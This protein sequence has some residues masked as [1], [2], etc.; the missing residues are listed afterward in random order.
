MSSSKEENDITRRQFLKNAA[1]GAG[2]AFLPTLHGITAKASSHKKVISVVQDAPTNIVPG[3]LTDQPGVNVCTAIYDKLFHLQGP[4]SE[5]G[6]WLV[7]DYNVSSDAKRW[8]FKLKE[9]V[10]FH[11]GTELTAEDVVFTFDRILNPDLGSAAQS[12]FTVVDNVEKKDQYT[13]NFELKQPNPNF[14][15]KFY[16]YNTQILAKDYD[17]DEYGSTK[18]SGTGPFKMKSYEP[19]SRVVL[20]RNPDY[21]V[22]DS[23]RVDELHI[24]IVPE[25]ATR[26]MLVRSGDADIAPFVGISEYKQFERSSATKGLSTKCAFH[27]PISMNTDKPPFD[28][29]KVRTAMK[30]CVDRKNMI[31]RVMEGEGDIGHDHPIWQGYQWYK[32]LGTRERNIEKAK[33]LLAEAGYEDGLEVDL[34]YGTTFPAVPSTALNFQQMAKPAGIDVRLVGSTGDVYYSKYWLQADLMATEWIHREN[35]VDLLKVAYKSDSD[36]N[37]TNYSNPELDKHIDAASRVL[38]EEKRQKHFTA[39]QKI[40]R[41]NDGRII[42]FFGSIFSGVNERVEDFWMTRV[43]SPEFRYVEPKEQ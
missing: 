38:D 17:Y 21:F 10:K 28:D 12:L 32:D 9:G 2:L 3:I 23:P 27:T 8:T 11:H 30:Y 42:P 5:R 1:A 19:G 20:E 39:I 35:P 13:V 33:Q 25:M 40:L 26:I 41:Q 37:E 43:S 15:L 31:N 29:K 6:P 7:E 16:D 14:N 36:W 22:P 18:P 24:R 4:E 34:N